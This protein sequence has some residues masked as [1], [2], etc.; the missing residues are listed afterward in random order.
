MSV[1]KSSDSQDQKMEELG[2]RLRTYLHKQ[3][4]KLTNERIAILKT[5]YRQE[6]HFTVDDIIELA[7][8]D[9]LNFSRATVYRTMDILVQAGLAKKQVFQGQ[10]AVYEAA[11]QSSHHDHLIC[12]DCNKIIEFFDPDLE[13]IQN[14]ILDKLGFEHVSHR[15]QIFARCLRPNCPERN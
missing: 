15:H 6:G 7:R 8:S 13:D 1:T 14:K 4:G 11:H 12:Q 9:G 2:E 5:L 3:N 10:E